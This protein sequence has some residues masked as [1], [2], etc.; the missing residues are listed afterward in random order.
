MLRRLLKLESDLRQIQTE[1][2][3]VE[4]EIQNHASEFETKENFYIQARE[5]FKNTIKVQNEEIR[6]LKLS[7]N[8]QK[9]ISIK[10]NKELNETQTKYKDEKLEMTKHFK[11]E[12]KMW[13]KKLGTQKK[14]T[15]KLEKKL[16]HLQ[17]SFQLLLLEIHIVK[18]LHTVPP[19]QYDC[20]PP[21]ASPRTP[22]S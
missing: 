13:K 18:P 10:L 9:S 14:K 7:N 6:D 17:M 1:K 8:N 19:A 15:L 4:N 16:K 12:L 2:N 20:Q 22:T 11:D 21:L 5:S 3:Y